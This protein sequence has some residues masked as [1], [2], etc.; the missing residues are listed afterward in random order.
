MTFV[1]SKS[2]AVRRWPPATPVHD[3]LTV[4]SVRRERSADILH[5]EVLMRMISGRWFVMGFLTVAALTS[6]VRDASAQISVG[7][8]GGV[9]SSSLTVSSS[10][11][12]FGELATDFGRRTGFTGGAFL[13][14]PL[15]KAVSFET[16]ALF[17]QKG[18]TIAVSIPDLGLAKGDFRL[19]FLEIPLLARVGIAKFSN[20]RLFV[21]G[22]ASIGVKLTARV[23]VEFQGLSDSQDISDDLPGTDIG[24]SIGGRIEAEKL[25]GEVRYTHGFTNLGD[26]GEVK[27]HVLAF[28]AGWRF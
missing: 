27:T 19:N 12:T 28:L 26:T 8:I 16:G 21:L 9:S 18:A 7:V 1:A 2:S 6:V 13:D 4:S 14:V 24:L 3:F 15:G 5:G 11:P 25:L 10:L 23:K 22:G 20:C 17:S